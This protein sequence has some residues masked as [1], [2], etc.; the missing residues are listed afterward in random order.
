MKKAF[1]GL[2]MMLAITVGMCAPAIAEPIT[3]EEAAVYL[4]PSIGLLKRTNRFTCTAWKMGS[5]EWATAWHC[6]AITGKEYTVHTQKPD[7]NTGGIRLKVKS[8][9]LPAEKAEGKDHFEDWAVLN[10]D[11]LTPNIPALPLNCKYELKLGETVAYMGFPG[12]AGKPME[13]FSTGI[14]TNM[15]T[16]KARPWTFGADLVGGPGASGSPV[17]SLKTAQVIGFLTKGIIGSRNILMSVGMESVAGMDYCTNKSAENAKIFEIMQKSQ[18]KYI[19][20]QGD[21]LPPLVH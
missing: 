21:S 7:E 12:Q 9:L 19:K 8:L 16:G 11:T 6:A 13:M 10:V 14:V 3:A 1:L 17:I 18:F 5:L 20:G 4:Q 15:E 2:A